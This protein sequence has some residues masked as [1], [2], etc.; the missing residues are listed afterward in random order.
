[1]YAWRCSK[2]NKVLLYSRRVQSET[3]NS[4][5]TCSECKENKRLRD[6]T[7]DDKMAGDTDKCKHDNAEKVDSVSDMD[8]KV[9]DIWKCPD[10]GLEWHYIFKYDHTEAPSGETIP[11]PMGMMDSKQPEN[12]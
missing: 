1:M 3:P 9:D 2:C 5:M 12:A 8:D 10:C 4:E 7:G 6:E 11:D